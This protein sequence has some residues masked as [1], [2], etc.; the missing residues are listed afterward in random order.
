MF[1]FILD[2]NNVKDLIF[3]YFFLLLVTQKTHYLPLNISF[4]NSKMDGTMLS[5]KV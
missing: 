3:S 5:C 1:G 4:Q 2:C